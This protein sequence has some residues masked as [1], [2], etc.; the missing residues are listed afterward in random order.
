MNTLK[1]DVKHSISVLLKRG[2]SHRRIARELGIHRE[3]VGKYS[4]E[5]SDSKPANP[6]TGNKSLCEEH[7]GLI[8]DGLDRGLT[9]QRIWQDLVSEHK[10]GYTAQSVRRYVRRLKGKE[11]ERFWRMEC[12]AGEEVQVDFCSGR[13][14]EGENGR[15]KKVHIFRIVLSHS[16]K[17]YS[18]AVSRQDT[19]SFLR[20]LENGFRHFGGVTTTINL[21]NLKAAVLGADWH[22]PT[23]NPKMV[24]FARFYATAILPTRPRKPEHKGKI[25]NGMGYV[26]RNALAGKRFISIGEINAHLLHWEKQIADQRIHG[27][28]RKQ[29][30]ALFEQEK[31]HL[32]ALPAGLFPFFHEGPR[33]V[34]RDS[35]V[36]VDKAFYQ[37]PPEH[38]GRQL[39]VR[40]DSRMVRIFTADLQPVTSHPRMEP[41]RF[42]HVLGCQGTPT[43]SMESSHKYYADKLAKIGPHVQAWAEGSWEARGPI[44]IRLLQ[45]LLA[46]AKD[47][48]ASDLDQACRKALDCGQWRM[49]D[50]RYWL[51]HPQIIPQTLPFLERHPLI[52]DLGEYQNMVVT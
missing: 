35:Y 25:E 31:P 12:E 36:A 2:W 44:S 20:C 10:V 41:G 29:V 6:I 47:H 45:G 26:Q 42:S 21:D 7:A 19:E 3:T 52:R 46:M 50:I 51:E 38:I 27:T 22:D 49:Q 37:V 43:G 34:H 18:Q 32:K 24:E 15:L 14:L 39:W 5:G 28:T 33:M 23:L 40:W 11:P 8:A 48:R 13:W 1:M 9:A 17:A 30:K 4:R 16:R